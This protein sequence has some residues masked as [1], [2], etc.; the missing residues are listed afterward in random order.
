MQIGYCYGTY[1]LSFCNSFYQT[2]NFTGSSH[3]LFNLQQ[4]YLLQLVITRGTAQ[5]VL[6]WESEW[7]LNGTSAQMRPFSAIYGV[8]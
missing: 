1:Y 6:Q 5:Y 2:A 8:D 4:Y 3:L 7:Y